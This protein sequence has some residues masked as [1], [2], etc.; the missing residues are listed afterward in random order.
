MAHIEF[1]PEPGVL[2][3][4]ND[5]SK[6]FAIQMSTPP[7]DILRALAR[8]IRTRVAY[9]KESGTRELLKLSAE[10]ENLKR[11]LHAWQP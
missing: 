10:L 11:E 3:T 9:A 2:Y 1:N 6:I 7:L 8:V 4:A 5:L